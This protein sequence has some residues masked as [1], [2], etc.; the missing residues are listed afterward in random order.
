MPRAPRDCKTG[1]VLWRTNTINSLTLLELTAALDRSRRLGRLD[2]T[3]GLNGA[4][5]IC[6]LQPG[7]W[8][9]QF[10]PL[11]S[12]KV[13]ANRRRDGNILKIFST[14]PTL[15]DYSAIFASRPVEIYQELSPGEGAP[16]SWAPRYSRLSHPRGNV[17]TAKST[18]E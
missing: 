5:A 13:S 16:N 1:Q 14:I 18:Q 3:A 17:F 7:L 11:I 9:A 4:A 15:V 6:K 12:R 8:A 10:I 2:A